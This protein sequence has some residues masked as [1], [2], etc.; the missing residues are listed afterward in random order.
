MV[1]L[2]VLRAVAHPV[3]LAILAECEGRGRTLADIAGHVGVSRPSARQHVGVLIDAGLLDDREG[4]LVSTSAGW[5][6]VLLALERLRVSST[7]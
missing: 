5:A 2:E 3:R 7:S 1:A 4:V 6:D